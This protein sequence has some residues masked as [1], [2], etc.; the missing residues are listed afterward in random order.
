MSTGKD[1]TASMFKLHFD[2]N[3]KTIEVLAKWPVSVHDARIFTER[4]VR[5][6]LMFMKRMDLK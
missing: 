2:A 6:N 3:Y 4:T 1:I 5:L